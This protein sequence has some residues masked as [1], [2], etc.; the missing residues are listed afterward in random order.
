MEERL[1]KIFNHYGFHNQKEKFKEEVLECGAA[2]QAYLNEP[3]EE[4]LKELK[5]EICDLMV[6]E[7]QFSLTDNR[8]KLFEKIERFYHNI[9]THYGDLIKNTFREN[10]K[11]IEVT[12]DRKI[13]RTLLKIAAEKG[14]C[15]E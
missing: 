4:H 3:S 13:D 1:I 9:V 14:R 15:S 12:M 6:V 7:K 8:D 2:L 10:R 5:E 11:E